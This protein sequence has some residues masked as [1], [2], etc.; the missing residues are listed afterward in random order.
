MAESPRR[1]DAQSASPSSTNPG[2][3]PPQDAPGSIK[4]QPATMIS[5]ELAK[6]PPP[7]SHEL[8]DLSDQML[9][10]F[11]LIRKLGAGGMAEVYLAEQTT[12]RR[13][14]AVKILRP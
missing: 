1:N 11:R 14:V 12:L 9:G 3:L 5:G 10:E 8:T 4:Q 6:S 2:S 13:Q 7:I